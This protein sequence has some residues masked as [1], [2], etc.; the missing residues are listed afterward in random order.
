MH[1]PTPAA[2]PAGSSLDIAFAPRH[3]APASVYPAARPDWNNLAVLH[4]N[5]LPTRAHFT[6]YPDASGARRAAADPRGTERAVAGGRDEALRQLLSGPGTTWRFDLAPSP[7][8]GPGRFHAPGFDASAWPPIRVPS[9]WQLQ[10][11]GRGPQYTNVVYPWPVDVPRVPADDNECGRYLHTFTVEDRLAPVASSGGVVRLRFEGVDAAYTVWLNGRHVGYSQGSRNPAEFD[12]TDI[13]DA[14][15]GP[16]TLAVEVYQR[17][18]GSYIEDQDMWW[19][20][21]IF[22][23]VSLVVWP[24]LHVVDYAV[25]TALDGEYKNA[26]LSVDL[27]L[28]REANFRLE[29]FG[30][31]GTR[32]YDSTHHLHRD[33]VSIDLED[34]PKWTAETP[35]LHTLL[36][37]LPGLSIAQRVGFRAVSISDGVFT[38]NGR[39]VILRGVNRHEHHPVHGRAV[40]FE[41]MRRDLVTMK[42]HNINALRTSH[43][44][45]DPR[46][47]DVAD[48]LGLW[49]LDE[50]DLEC[51][52]LEMVAGW[53]NA[54][55]Y[56][57]DNPDWEAAYL[58]RARQMV[59]RDRNHACVVV[60][61]LG[62]EAFY[63]RNHRAMARLIREIDPS[64]PIHYQPDRD[65]ETADMFGEFYPAVDWV[66][67]R[68][69]DA[70]VQ[71][72][73]LL[74]EYGHAMG[75]GPGNLQEYLDLFYK[76]PRLMGGFIWEWANHGLRALD[77]AGE[78]YMGYGGDFGDDPHDKNFVMDGLCNSDHEPMPGL[79]EYAKAI[80]PVQ[81]LRLDPG[82]KEVVI[83]NRYDFITLDHLLAQATIIRGLDGRAANYFVEI[84]LGIQP[85]TE[86]RIAVTLPEDAHDAHLQLEFYLAESTNW[87]AARHVVATGELALSPPA[88]LST[89][90]NSLS[91]DSHFFAPVPTASL[92]P[93]DTTLT[94]TSSS[95]ASTWG[96][97][98]ISGALTSWRKPFCE[99][100]LA[101]PVTLGL[102]RALTDNDRG[103]LG[104][105][106]LD[107]R[108]HQARH[109]ARSVEW[110]E[111]A[112][113]VRVV[114]DGRIAPPVFAWGFDT[115]TT[116]DFHHDHVSVRVRGVPA[117]LPEADGLETLPR[118]G[119]DL[120]LRGVR[121]ARWLGRGPGESYRDKKR[122]QL[123][124]KYHALVDD[125]QTSYDFPQ[126]GGNRT[127]TR[128]VAFEESD[129]EHGYFD[130]DDGRDARVLLKASFGDLPDASFSASRVSPLEV[131]RAQ[132]PGDLRRADNE[133]R[134]R[135]ETLVRLDWAH[136]GL[137]SGSCGPVTLDK[138]R[139]GGGEFEFE[140]L[141]E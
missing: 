34:P 115:T 55:R 96:V 5:R 60:W 69:A 20:S 85:H 87:A 27:A 118:I 127:D 25:E 136:T 61:S 103:A 111:S 6:A 18:D 137:G 36:I 35:A 78:P 30:P 68:G 114:V 84:P 14:R 3:A 82:G 21:G 81:V 71:K 121:S 73:T 104:K 32:L 48:E 62:N 28:S 116:L 95:G 51:H 83:V 63:G 122:S 67:A 13:V 4:R 130:D 134:A 128:W 10:G 24:G 106:W 45:N 80:E 100:I 39:P 12:V 29:L 22:R 108:V 92:A 76:H 135:D 23:D 102:F 53:D 140:V 64:R 77:A 8:A 46:L 125:L 59:L 11:H 41:Y 132:H 107:K 124:G 19:L 97:D 56:T 16:N 93:N 110:H 9:M 47:Y 17:C 79:K 65:A 26:T 131:E 98:L 2:L 50:A 15:G 119:L 1:L 129:V 123:F 109:T 126:E 70:G 42:Q 141:L 105:A 37:T 40:P 89:I 139:L 72:P 44:P 138:Y 66:D 7:H 33:K 90:V 54:H 99:N 49:V 113:G 101:A 74:V 117:Q 120:A 133:R 94:I 88:S 86:A 57:S 38:V 91:M 31:D 75:N 52:G 43:Y 58:D 112:S